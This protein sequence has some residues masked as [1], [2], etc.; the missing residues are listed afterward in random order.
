MYF[1]KIIGSLFLCKVV[2]V[3]KWCVLILD[4]IFVAEA[5][6]KMNMSK[7]EMK[8][9]A[10]ENW[11]MSHL[12]NRTMNGKYHSITQPHQTCT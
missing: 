9:M 11:D 12:Y 3:R 8:M 2:G 5:V 6:M 10:M 1:R 4:V 7:E